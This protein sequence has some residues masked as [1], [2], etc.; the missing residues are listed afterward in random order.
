MAKVVRGLI[1]R[2]LNVRRPAR[3]MSKLDISYV[4]MCV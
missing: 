1:V 3:K 4:G 2:D